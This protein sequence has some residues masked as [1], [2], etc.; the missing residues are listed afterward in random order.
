MSSSPPPPDRNNKIGFLTVDEIFACVKD[1]AFIMDDDMD[2]SSIESSF[3][4]ALHQFFNTPRPKTVAQVTDL[5]RN[6]NVLVRYCS[7]Q[8][9]KR[10][11]SR[12]TSFVLAVIHKRYHLKSPQAKEEEA[13]AAQEDTDA[14]L[15]VGD[16]ERLVFCIAVLHLFYRAL[17]ITLSDNA[18]DD[19]G[20]MQAAV[21]VLCAVAPLAGGT[22][23]VCSLTELCLRAVLDEF[24]VKI[25]NNSDDN[26]DDSYAIIAQHSSTLVAAALQQAAAV[27]S[28]RAGG[29]CIMALK[30]M[31]G[32]MG[33]A[34]D[35]DLHLVTA[36][37][38][39]SDA[40]VENKS[41]KHQQ[42]P[43]TKFH[44]FLPHHGRGKTSGAKRRRHGEKQQRTMNNRNLIQSVA[45]ILVWSNTETVRN[46]PA[47]ASAYEDLV[48]HDCMALVVNNDNN[49]NQAAKTSCHRIQTIARKKRQVLNRFARQQGFMLGAQY[50]I[51]AK[52]IRL[53]Q[54]KRAKTADLNR[55]TVL[56]TK[57][58]DTTL[59]KLVQA[60]FLDPTKAPA[61]SSVA[62]IINQWCPIDDDDDDDHHHNKDDKNCTKW[63]AKSNE[64]RFGRPCP[65]YVPVGPNKMADSKNPWWCVSNHP[66]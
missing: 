64:P 19:G 28:S 66:N 4:N 23:D 14:V 38:S 11:S 40:A 26:D 30:E 17:I 3:D 33:T 42:L 41:N 57:K 46:E 34:L 37:M 44:V 45:E 9:D 48:Q 20:G 32:L 12:W 56:A 52:Q 61:A 50:K 31:L 25:E 39:S 18:D 10:N 62:E 1:T 65:S 21:Q 6:I 60:R 49:N 51:D 55:L 47:F 22:R 36:A 2:A 24:L 16:G 27:M 59:L 43:S 5:C 63:K 53:A 13:A 8:N 54:I 15:A 7:C 29:A 58:Q 35:A